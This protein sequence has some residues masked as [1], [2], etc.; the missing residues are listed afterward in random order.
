[1]VWDFG[2][3][4]RLFIKVCLCILTQTHDYYVEAEKEEQEARGI[5]TGR[6]TTRA[7]GGTFVF[8]AAAVERG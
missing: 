2:W 3:P 7:D 1:M 5:D 8:E 6:G 4:K